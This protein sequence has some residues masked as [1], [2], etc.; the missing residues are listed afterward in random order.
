MLQRRSQLPSCCC[1]LLSFGCSAASLC[2][3]ARLLFQPFRCDDWFYFAIDPAFML[4]RESHARG[5]I[6]HESDWCSF[7]VVLNGEPDWSTTLVMLTLRWVD[8]RN[9]R[10]KLQHVKSAVSHSIVHTR[11]VAILHCAL[12]W[13]CDVF[14]YALFMVCK[15]DLNPS[16][17]NETIVNH[18]SSRTTSENAASFSFVKNECAERE[19]GDLVMRPCV[20]SLGPRGI[21]R[22]EKTRL[23]VWNEDWDVN[24]KMALK[25]WRL[26]WCIF[27]YRL[28]RDV[29]MK[30]ALKMCKA[31]KRGA[32]YY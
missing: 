23:T 13:R 7:S 19:K 28:W 30:T 27:F 32:F 4:L 20:K 22:V 14:V 6:Q 12:V 15:K 18:C 24:M 8:Q 5:R 25:K 16:P 11:G 1:M 21:S 2:P 31:S 29:N 10:S 17:G 3:P 26:N 9:R